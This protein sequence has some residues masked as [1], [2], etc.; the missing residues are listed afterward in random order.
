MDSNKIIADLK[1]LVNQYKELE[2]DLPYD[3]CKEYFFLSKVAFLMITPDAVKRGMLSDIITYLTVNKHIKVCSAK[4][5]W[6]STRDIEILYK[7]SFRRKILDGEPAYWW[8]MERCLQ[9]GPCVGLV[10]YSED[11]DEEYFCEELVKIKGKYSEDNDSKDND[12]IRGKFKSISRIFNTVHCSDNIFNVLRESAIFYSLDEFENI[13]SNVQNKHFLPPEYVVELL[14]GGE[15]ITRDTAD[16]LRDIVIRIIANINI[17]INLVDNINRDDIY[18][19]YIR[20]RTYSQF[21]ESVSNDRSIAQ[22]WIS[23]LVILYSIEGEESVPIEKIE[24]YLENTEL[25]LTDF[26]KL[27]ILNIVVFKKWNTYKV[28]NTKK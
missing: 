9:L 21:W 17:E 12:T 13:L 22:R 15:V 20:S 7:Y 28:S 14:Q 3:I 26:E 5:K 24:Y 16:I 10:L 11:F 6:L 19:K 18:N 25:Y 27:V 1:K 4:T 2:Y 23:L 8:L